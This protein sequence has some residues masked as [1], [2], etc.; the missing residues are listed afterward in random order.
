MVEDS[1]LVFAY[2]STTSATESSHAEG[3]TTEFGG[4]VMKPH[5]LGVGL[6]VVG[7][8]KAAKFRQSG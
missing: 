3:A 4:A 6:E 1:I 5:R 8:D 2:R 7:I